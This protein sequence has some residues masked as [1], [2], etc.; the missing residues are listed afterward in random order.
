MAKATTDI[1]PAEVEAVW[2]PEGD[3]AP[4]DGGFAAKAGDKARE[5]AEY[6]KD[7]VSDGLAELSSLVSGVADQV[8]EK[9]GP[10]YGDY[11]RKAASAVSGAADSLKSAEVDDLVEGTRKFVREKPV[12]AIGAAAAVGFLLTR[13]FRAGTRTNDDA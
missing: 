3:K 8:T 12:I 1:E 4:G 5:Y 13:L 11:A 2:A 6:G 7:K 9:L 10:H